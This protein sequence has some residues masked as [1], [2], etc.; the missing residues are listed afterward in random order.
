MPTTPTRRPSE[1]APGTRARTGGTT[2]N[3]THHRVPRLP[4]ER[5]ESADSQELQEPGQREVM[6]Q[7]SDDI[8]HGLEDTDR[9]PVLDRVYR[10]RLKQP[11]KG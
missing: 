7:A 3:V 5:D 2:A 11:R 6:Q 4:H 9:G 1:K 10:E 8:E